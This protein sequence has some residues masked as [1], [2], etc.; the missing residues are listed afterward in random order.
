MKWSLTFTSILL[1]PISLTRGMTRKGRLM[2][3]VVRYLNIATRT[4][5]NTSKLFYSSQNVTLPHQFKLSIRR[6]KTDTSFRLKLT[7]FDALMER[8]VIDGY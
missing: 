7:Q 2:S 3:L 6:Y 8:A 4:C 5:F 1:R